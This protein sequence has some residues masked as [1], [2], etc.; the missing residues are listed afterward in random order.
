MSSLL[1]PSQNRTGRSS[2]DHPPPATPSRLAGGALGRLRPIE[3]L[4]KEIKRCA[5]VVGI[6]PIEASIRRFLGAI[7]P[8]QDDE[9]QLQ[10]RYMTLETM[11]NRGDDQAVAFP[12]IA[13]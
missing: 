12:H 7:L 9:W 6:F 11:I 4:N 13:A 5:D 1:W 3:R 8:E 2:I 10:H